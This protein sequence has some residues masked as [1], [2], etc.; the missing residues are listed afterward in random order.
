MTTAAIGGTIETRKQIW[1][2]LESRVSR[3]R[4]RRWRRLETEPARHCQLNP[5]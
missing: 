1:A 2:L 3:N 4:S 5:M